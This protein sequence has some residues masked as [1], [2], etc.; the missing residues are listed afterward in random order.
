ML[1]M[2]KLQPMQTI[3]DKLPEY[4][5]TDTERGSSINLVYMAC[6]RKGENLEKTHTET[7][8]TC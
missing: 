5:R 1:V 7:R 6:G 2:G 8:R 3:L 4:H